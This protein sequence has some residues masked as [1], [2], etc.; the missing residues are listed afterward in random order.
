MAAE[1]RQHLPVLAEAAVDALRPGPDRR[2]VDATY[3]RG[4]HA[5]LILD[6]LGETGELLAL[7]RD[8][9]AVAHGRAEFA[10][11]PRFRILRHPF[12]RIGPAVAEAGW[13]EGVDGILA[14]LGV[15]SPQLDDAARGFSFRE[16]GPLDMRMDPGAGP[17]A[18]EWLRE[19]DPGELERVL[20]E[21]GEERHARR[22]ARAILA[23]RERLATTGDLAEVVRAAVPGR[24]EPGKDKA[25]RTFQ[26]VRMAVN[27]ELGELEAFLEAAVEV[28][29]PGGRL[30]VIAF[31]SLED[32]MVKRFIREEA[33]DCVC[34]PDFPVCR[35]DKAARLRPVGKPLR[36]GPE[37]REVN[38]RARSAIARVA[39]RLAA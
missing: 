20:R 30:V 2:L 4:G 13:T 5:R 28:L 6:R 33:R 34:P 31:H 37:E 15:S 29:R 21:Y 17:S 7:D 14:D 12:S 32:R 11:D 8:P 3:G 19:V 26:A 22:V 16:E 23:A 38:P 25:T 18:A 36:P 1:G 39:E 10:S 27:D 35:C 9:E 24:G